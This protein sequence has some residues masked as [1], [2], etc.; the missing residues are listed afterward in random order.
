MGVARSQEIVQNKS[1]YRSHEI[2]GKLIYYSTVIY[3]SNFVFNHQI[4]NFPLFSPLCFVK[5]KTASLI[6][7]PF[8]GILRNSLH[9]GI[10]SLVSSDLYVIFESQCLFLLH[11]I[12]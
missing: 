7:E 8:R 3:R 11:R 6:N 4:V 12:F 9:C 5:F 2:G 1:S 10:L